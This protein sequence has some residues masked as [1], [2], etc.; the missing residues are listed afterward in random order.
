MPPP[1][2]YALKLKPPPVPLDAASAAGGEE[3]QEEDE[4]E[5]EEEQH[6]R[7]SGWF[8]CARACSAAAAAAAEAKAKAL[9][10]CMPPPL[11]G[12]AGL[13]E[14][15]GAWARCVV[16]ALAAWSASA[17]ST[18]DTLSDTLL[19]LL[20]AVALGG[21]ELPNA[22][23]PLADATLTLCPWSRPSEPGKGSSVQ[24]GARIS[25]LSTAKRCVLGSRQTFL[26]HRPGFAHCGSTHVVQLMSFNTCPSTH[27][28]QFNTCPS[29][30]PECPHPNRRCSSAAT[31]YSPT[32]RI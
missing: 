13:A 26:L 21:R 22:P 32:F 8:E 17:S 7:V 2:P 31:C 18:T 6:E 12:H 14:V 4:E 25:F 11:T 29:T 24:R 10:A 27:V 1:L 9:T 30:H 28:L 15:A 20:S 23:W 5:E 3:G 16:H 19:R